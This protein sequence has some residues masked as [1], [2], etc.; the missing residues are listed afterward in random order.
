MRINID[1]RMLSLLHLLNDRAGFLQEFQRLKQSGFINDD[2]WNKIHEMSRDLGLK[3]DSLVSRVNTDRCGRELRPER[4]RMCLDRRQQDRRSI[5]LSWL[6]A[7]RRLG[8][9][10]Q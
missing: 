3:D 6:G 5:T 1:L 10:R 2:A 4:R 8:E 9:R 7:D